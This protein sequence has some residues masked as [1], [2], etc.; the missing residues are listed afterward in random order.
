MHPMRRSLS[1]DTPRFEP[2][3]RPP[4]FQVPCKR[5]NGGAAAAGSSS[6]SKGRAGTGPKQPKVRT[7]VRALSARVR[8]G[9][10]MSR[11]LT[12]PPIRP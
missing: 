7:N 11:W 5:K 10:A 8:G 9:A 12:F 6:G 1:I 4:T 3:E 2:T